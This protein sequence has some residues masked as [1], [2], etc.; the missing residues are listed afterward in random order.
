MYYKKL[1]LKTLE[2]YCRRERDNPQKFEAT[3]PIADVSSGARQTTATH[4]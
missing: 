2:T 1:K 3:G 4:G